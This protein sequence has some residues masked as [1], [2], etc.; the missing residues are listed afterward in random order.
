MFVFLFKS[1]QECHTVLISANWPQDKEWVVGVVFVWPSSK[2]RGRE[3]SLQASKGVGDH[4]YRNQ[5][6]GHS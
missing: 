5:R 3:K 4:L 1:F 2:V 6:G